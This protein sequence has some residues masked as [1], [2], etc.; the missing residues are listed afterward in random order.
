M[1]HKADDIF[2]YLEEIK[3]YCESHINDLTSKIKCKDCVLYDKAYEQCVF[4]YSPHRWD[5]EYLKATNKGD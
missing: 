3:K 5:V 4:L 2:L 1:E